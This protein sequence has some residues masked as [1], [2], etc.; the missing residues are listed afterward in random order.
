LSKT[1]GVS[2]APEQSIEQSIEESIEEPIEEPIEQPIRPAATVIV[3][4]DASPQF[5]I[6]ML[7]RTN[8]AVF[9]GGMY[10]FPGGRVDDEDASPVYERVLTGPTDQQR[11]QRNALGEHWQR[12]WLTGIRETFEEAGILLAYDT[13]GAVLSYDGSAHD[14]F[15][16]YRAGLHSGDISLAEICEKEQLTLAVDLIHF[17]NRWITPPGRP[18]RFDTRFFITQAPPSQ[19]GLHD[20]L[21][22]VDSRWISPSRALELYRQDEF[23]LMKV[24][25]RQLDTFNQ[26]QSV[27]EFI[28]MAKEN[29][30]FPT[31][32]P[33]AP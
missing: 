2:Q 27:E 15:H 22:T 6:F 30:D 18:R 23:G 26:F 32:N 4:R 8:A 7:R 24:T 31:Y 3:A 21:E 19:S 13:T 10:V 5:E 33:G 28:T 1:P 16:G 9:A 25:E 29:D 12:Y 20:G 14:R 17:F 11:P